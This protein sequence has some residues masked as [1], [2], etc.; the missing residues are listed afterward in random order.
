LYL[1]DTYFFFSIFF[2]AVF[3]IHK[4][5]WLVIWDVSAHARQAVDLSLALA[6]ALTL[7]VEVGN[8][9]GRNRG[10]SVL[11]LSLVFGVGQFQI[12]TFGVINSIVWPPLIG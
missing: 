5:L 8:C 11:L 10:W 9:N 4:F 7:A 2:S 12:Y 1:I 3:G 6:L